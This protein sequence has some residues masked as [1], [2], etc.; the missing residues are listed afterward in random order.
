[1][2]MSQLKRVAKVLGK[3]DIF[4]VTVTGGEPFLYKKKLYYFLD[5]LISQNIR[6]M[7]NSNATL[8]NKEDAKVLSKYPLD[9]FLASIISHNAEQHDKIANAYGSHQK[10]VNGIKTLLEYGITTAVNMVATKLNYKE[11]YATGKWLHNYLG[12]N[13]FSATP[14][15]PSTNSHLQL[16][17]DNRETF[18]VLNQPLLLKRELKLHVDILEVMPTCLFTETDNK[19]I[20]D[21]FSTRICTAGNTTIT[22][23]S[24]GDVR[25]CSFDQ[26]S[27]GNILQENFTA[28]WSRMEK[29]RDDSLLPEECKDCIAVESCGGGCKISVKEDECKLNPLAKNAIKER[30]D[31]FFSNISRDIDMNTNFRLVK[32]ISF[33]E[34]KKGIFLIVA[35]PMQFVIVDKDG[36]SLIRRLASLD[37]FVPNEA[38]DIMKLDSKSAKTFFAE[39]RNKNIMIKV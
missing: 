33:R 18:E 3:N 26:R 35:N 11:V 8:I 27:Y 14:I 10:T 17:L 7:I 31:E 4:Y 36:A 37:C 15:C 25:V 13:N 29:W 6:V 2:T 19:E 38:I 24:E 9:I 22:I 16:A 34:E 39:L 28:I 1:M 20:V 21:I 30:R 5:C 32:N 12:I 23:G